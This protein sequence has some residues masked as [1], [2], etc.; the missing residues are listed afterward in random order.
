[1]TGPRLPAGS[2]HGAARPQEP[3]GLR[4]QVAPRRR[5]RDSRVAARL[6]A[7][8]TGWVPSGWLAPRARGRH[9]GRGAHG[10]APRLPSHAATPSCGGAAC[11]RGPVP[12]P[13]RCRHVGGCHGGGVKGTQAWSRC[14]THSAG[15]CFLFYLFLGG[16][17]WQ[18]LN[19]RKRL[20]RPLGLPLSLA[21]PYWGPP[22]YPFFTCLLLFEGSGANMLRALPVRSV[23]ND[24]AFPELTVWR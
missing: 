16:F 19:R 15:N 13:L 14:K 21:W 3:C 18:A 8:A 1:M 12:P 6:R 23:R 9:A 24:S 10:V 4:P 7:V 2:G 20:L 22:V 11:G 5:H 17:F